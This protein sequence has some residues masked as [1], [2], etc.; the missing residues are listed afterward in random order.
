[1]KPNKLVLVNQEYFNNYGFDNHFS[2]LYELE[3]KISE[4]KEGEAE[5]VLA[6]SYDLEG[7]ALFD[8]VTYQPAMNMFQHNSYVYEF[9]GSVK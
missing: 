2:I 1:M 5:E 6:I 9:T 8:F 4:Y 3:K 7:F